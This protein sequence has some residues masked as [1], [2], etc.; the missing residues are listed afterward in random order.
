MSFQEPCRPVFRGAPGP[1]VVLHDL[2]L[3]KDGWLM[4]LL[5]PSLQDSHGALE[6]FS[7]DAPSSMLPSPGHAADVARKPRVLSHCPPC[8]CL[9]PAGG[10]QG[11]VCSS[12][13]W[14]LEKH[15]SVQLW[16]CWGLANSWQPSQQCWQESWARDPQSTLTILQLVPDKTF[17]SPFTM[18]ESGDFLD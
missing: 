14:G 10:S 7:G 16:P 6:E 18:K 8:D 12:P 9:R 2:R 3:G 11:R 1:H 5:V 15:S 13:G 4:S 17:C